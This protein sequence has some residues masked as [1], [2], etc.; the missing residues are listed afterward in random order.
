L[1]IKPPVIQS[2]V[3]T[4]QSEVA[5]Q[6]KDPMAKAGEIGLARDF[7]KRTPGEAVRELKGHGIRRFALDDRGFDFKGP[8]HLGFKMPVIQSQ[9]GVSY[10]VKLLCAGSNNGELLN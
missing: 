1:Q 4:E 7:G 2:G 10:V 6:S 5:T 8:S 3:V 9:V